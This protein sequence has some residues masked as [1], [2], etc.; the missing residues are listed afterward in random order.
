MYF[1]ILEIFILKT[2]F[3]KGEYN[4]TSKNFNPIKFLTIMFL[5]FNFFFTLFL[6]SKISDMYEKVNKECPAILQQDETDKK[7]TSIK[8]PIEDK[9]S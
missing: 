1:K 4:I 5:V 9:K 3:S 8:K 2:L 6:V 7:E